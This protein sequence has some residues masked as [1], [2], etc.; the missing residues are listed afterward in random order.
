M[1]F[2]FWF[3]I[4]V[5]GGFERVLD[6][7]VVFVFLFIVGLRLDGECLRVLRI[8]EYKMNFSSDNIYKNKNF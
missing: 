3:L 2:V 7:D 5:F 1:F 6:L 8:K 4:F